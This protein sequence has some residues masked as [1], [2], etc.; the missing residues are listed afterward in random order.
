MIS[1]DDTFIDLTE[2]LNEQERKRKTWKY[3]LFRFINIITFNKFF[4][5]Y[6]L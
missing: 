5:K 1:R 3:T 2:I 4:K 6:T